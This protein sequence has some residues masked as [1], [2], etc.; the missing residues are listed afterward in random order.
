MDRQGPAKESRLPDSKQ[1][2]QF[3]RFTGL[4]FQM[5]VTIGVSGWV[6]YKVDIW[7]N[8]LPL[9]LILLLLGS[10]AGQIYLLIKSDRNK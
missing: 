2:N 8:T 3:L 7:L 1:S 4:G 9:F 5:M 6:G 10:F